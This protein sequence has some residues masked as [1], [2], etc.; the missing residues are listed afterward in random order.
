M[1]FRSCLLRLTLCEKT[2]RVST[3]RKVSNVRE[4][5][6]AC[7][8]DQPVIKDKTREDASVSHQ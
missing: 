6:L 3:K 5:N 2:A 8:P 1:D 7:A 4:D